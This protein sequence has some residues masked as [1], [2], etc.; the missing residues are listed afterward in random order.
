MSCSYTVLPLHSILILINWPILWPIIALPSL[1]PHAF[2]Q[3]WESGSHLSDHCLT[4]QAT[5]TALT[6]GFCSQPSTEARDIFRLILGKAPSLAFATFLHNKVHCAVVEPGSGTWPG[7]SFS[8]EQ[9]LD[10]GQTS[11]SDT[12]SNTAMALYHQ[13]VAGLSLYFFD[14][15]GHLAKQ[16]SA[17]LA[18]HSWSAHLALGQQ[19]HRTLHQLTHSYVPA[20]SL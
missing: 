4:T 12:H 18:S 13:P 9:Q 16:H 10:K 14:R 19:L 6:D 1:V 8:L 7:F 5:Q 11:H 3:L 20:S 17:R 2:T 15:S